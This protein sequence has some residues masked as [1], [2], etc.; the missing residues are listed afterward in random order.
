MGGIDRLQDSVQ[1]G[2]SATGNPDADTLLRENPNALLIAVLLDQQV[3]AEL[4]FE[5][6]YKLMSRLGH[7]NMKDL[8][9]A[10][11]GELKTIFGQKPAV[12]RFYNK[13]AGSVQEL[14]AYLTDHYE[15]DAANLWSDA[16]SWD[17]IESRVSELPGFGASKV[18]T[19][20]S[21]LPLFGYQVPA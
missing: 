16:D 19:L 18:A 7:L 8:A 10:D 21:A 5:G 14:A 6:P 2:G 1:Q 15:A 11:L 3:K 12:H 9:E 20:R 13:M 4:A 17:E